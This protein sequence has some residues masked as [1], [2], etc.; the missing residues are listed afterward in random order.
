MTADAGMRQALFPNIRRRTVR[1]VSVD[2]ITY[3]ARH[4]LESVVIIII[5][6]MMMMMMIV[7]TITFILIIIYYI[8]LGR[9]TRRTSL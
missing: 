2:W 7:I 6:M 4:E 8:C 1:Y 3:L 5:I 9:N